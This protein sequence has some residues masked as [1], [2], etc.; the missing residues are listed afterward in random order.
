M[1]KVCKIKTKEEL[2]SQ[3]GLMVLESNLEQLID[4]SVIKN[5]YVYADKLQK[6]KDIT[7]KN[8]AL[9]FIDTVTDHLAEYAEIEGE[10][11]SYLVAKNICENE[12]GIND[13]TFEIPGSVKRGIQKSAEEFQKKYAEKQSVV[14][15][16]FDTLE[17]IT[18]DL[19]PENADQLDA[20]REA[21]PDLLPD[22]NSLMRRDFTNT[23][24]NLNM[25]ACENLTMGNYAKRL[26]D[27][28]DNDAKQWATNAIE[29]MVRGLYTNDGYE[30]LTKNSN[31]II[32]SI[33]IDGEPAAAKYINTGNYNEKCAAII[34]DV[35]S[36]KKI[37]VRGMDMTNGLF[38]ENDKV[39][40]VEVVPNVVCEEKFSLWKAILRFFGIGKT[41]EKTAKQKAEEKISFAQLGNEDAIAQIKG[42]DLTDREFADK[43]KPVRN[44][45]NS[46]SAQVK[47]MDNF[48]FGEIVG[49]PTDYFM[50]ASKYHEEYND[51]G[52]AESTLYLKT[53]GRQGSRMSIF[54]TYA[55]SKGMS[56]D[57]ILNPS[58]ADKQQ[59]KTYGKEFVDIVTLPQR[60]DIAKQVYPDYTAEQIQNA[61]TT[62]DKQ[63][64]TAYDNAVK[65]KSDE[66]IEMYGNLHETLSEFANTLKSVD[67]MDME[68]VAEALP[69]HRFFSLAC[70]DLMQTIDGTPL[71]ENND[72]MEEIAQFGFDNQFK[73]PLNA[74]YSTFLA[75]PEAS[76]RI[77]YG[78]NVT[79]LSGALAA[80]AYLQPPKD[81]AN[82]LA[83]DA[84]IL[85][86]YQGA[87]SD[88]LSAAAKSPDSA[89]VFQYAKDIIT[90]KKP[91]PEGLISNMKTNLINCY[92]NDINM[93]AEKSLDKPME[94]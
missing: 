57:A 89:G 6:I 66:I 27:P 40:S 23:K 22:N 54:M 2:I 7:P 91:I 60:E 28:M 11:I 70:C 63:F 37:N 86:C 48:V 30:K 25:Y 4:T 64:R 61:I 46:Y 31:N 53:L 81:N 14:D 36:G 67:Y 56:L 76:L 77:P 79:S 55:M 69:A 52:Y 17:F 84:V 72:K 29:N 71:I 75:T 8:G 35:L 12:H 83:E 34:S 51:K 44:A 1:G 32:N 90:G 65:A 42:Y 93:Q 3:V 80:I 5:T 21:N 15:S 78:K 88:E 19:T 49:N 18:Y 39:A 33:Y 85:S 13:I 59:L 16:D 74:M 9:G 62:N 58:E 68:A 94:R 41:D 10:Y 92:N 20:V 47:N 45:D 73:T 26:S 24:M 38:V 82:C 87:F 50:K 43:T